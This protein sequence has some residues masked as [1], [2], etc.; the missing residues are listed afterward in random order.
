MGG[1][2]RKVVR[3]KILL[4]PHFQFASYAP[5]NGRR[6]EKG[7]QERKKRDGKGKR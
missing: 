2:K 5:G 6:K 1:G 3:Q 7:R 4:A